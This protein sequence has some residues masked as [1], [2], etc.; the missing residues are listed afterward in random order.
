[1]NIL[2]YS[3]I[4]QLQI[5]FLV[6]I[7]YEL[8]IKAST[9]KFINPSL[10]AISFFFLLHIYICTLKITIRTHLHIRGKQQADGED[11]LK[12]RQLMELA[13]INGTYRDSSTKATAAGNCWCCSRFSSLSLSL[14]CAFY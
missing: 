1:M 4:I 5:N 2:N 12:K 7:V 14:N 6:L 11:E 10:F 13:I 3:I 9:H 8:R